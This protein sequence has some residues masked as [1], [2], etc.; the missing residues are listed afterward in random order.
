METWNWKAK[1]M[2]CSNCALAIGKYLENKKIKVRLL[3][4]N[5][6][7]PSW[8]CPQFLN[9]QIGFRK[10]DTQAILEL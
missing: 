4:K 10:T 1:G 7:G 8:Y 3:G 2:S 5:P 6:P 9:L